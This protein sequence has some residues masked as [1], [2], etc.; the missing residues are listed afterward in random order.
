[1]DRQKSFSKRS[2]RLKGKHRGGHREQGGRSGNEDN[3]KG[4][5]VGVEGSETSRRS[6]P[7]VGVEDVLEGGPSQEESS[8]NQED[9]APVDDLPTSTPSILQSRKS[10]CM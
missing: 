2:K 3:R 7:G 6:Y 9:A 8:V 5:E 1:M 4:R 10:D